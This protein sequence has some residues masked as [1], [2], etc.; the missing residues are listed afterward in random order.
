MLL[1]GFMYG[2]V[3][4]LFRFVV[5][6]SSFWT[7]LSYEYI[8]SGIGGMLL[9]LLPKVRKSLSADLRQVKASAG[10]ITVNNGIAVLAGMSESFAVSLAAV[11]LVNL[12]GSI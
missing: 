9:F 7:T 10:I 4:I 6:E 5:K 3:G 1:S 8:G 2:L 11:P 12:L